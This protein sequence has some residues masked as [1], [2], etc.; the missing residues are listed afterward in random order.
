MTIKELI[1]ELTTYPETLPIKIF[2]MYGSCFKYSDIENI[3]EVHEIE[4]NPQQEIILIIPK[5]TL[6]D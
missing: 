2:D 3:L 1:N 5:C 6:Q 4:D